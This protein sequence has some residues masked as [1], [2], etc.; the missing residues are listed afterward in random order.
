MSTLTVVTQHNNWMDLRAAHEMLCTTPGPDDTVVQRIIDELTAMIEGYLGRNL[1]DGD[2]EET[3]YRQQ[4]RHLTLSVWP[5]TSITSITEDGVALSEY[6]LV[7]DIGQI[8]RDCYASYWD[9]CG[10]DIVVEYRAGYGT[11][12]QELQQIF[13]ELVE[14]RYSS[15]GSTA[16]SSTV[17]KVNLVGLGAVEF[18]SGGISYSGVDRQLDVPEELR[19]YVGILDRYKSDRS[20]GV[21]V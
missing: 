21:I 14:G 5:V 6:Q 7:P 8:Y 12:P 16:S 18:E 19:D 13:R 10:G 2:Y 20:I 11:I 9:S 3:L 4:G 15:G 1:R 17:K